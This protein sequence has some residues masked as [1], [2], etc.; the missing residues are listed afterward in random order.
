MATLTYFQVLGTY[1]AALK[2]SLYDV[3]ND[4]E[5]TPMSGAVTF[6]PLIDT[7]DLIPTPTLSPPANLQLAPV[8]A[9]IKSGVITTNG[10]PGVKLVANT[11]VLGLSGN[12]FYRVDFYDG[13]LAGGK[14]FHPDSF[15]FQAPLTATTV[16]LVEVTPLPGS[17][18]IGNVLPVVSVGGKT[19]AIILT[20]DDVSDFGVTG[21]S[22]AR[23]ANQTAAWTALGS[24]PT[25]KLPNLALIQFKGAKA[26]QAAMLA[27][28][29]EQGDWVTRSDTST[30]WII[31]G[32]DPTQ[33]SNWTQLPIPSLGANLIAIAGLTSAAD[34]IPFFTGS[35]TAATTPLTVAGRALLDDTDAA[36]QRTTLHS[37]GGSVYDAAGSPVTNK[38]ARI[39]L[40]SNGDID[41]IIM[42]GI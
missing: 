14:T 18:A 8:K 41:D 17:P 13:L 33:L 11:A 6:T 15:T 37:L 26:D 28:T 3:D 9:Q 12:L 16:D 27:T 23:S 21:K 36:A 1:L 2:D 4:P 30:A 35:G 24:V 19:G 10:V 7:G 5:L 22:L 38:G 29:G 34:K 40:D 20:A 31:T 32:A 42:E 39:V 25:D